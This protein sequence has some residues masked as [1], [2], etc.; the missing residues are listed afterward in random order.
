MLKDLVL[1][2]EYDRALTPNI[3]DLFMHSV[4]DPDSYVYL[5]AV[6]GLAG[7]VDALG[8]EVLV[9]LV[10]AYRT[11]LIKAEKRGME[12][13]EME[14]ALRIAEALSLVVRRL[15]EALSAYGKSRRKPF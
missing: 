12:Q 2:P 8:K 4:Q 1:S 15:G 10:G 5:N 14:K 7:M 9:S 13:D 11:I 3:M 6:K